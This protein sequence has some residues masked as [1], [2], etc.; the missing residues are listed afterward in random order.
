MG[1]GRQLVAHGPGS[2]IAALGTASRLRR[3]RMTAVQGPRDLDSAAPV[4]TPGG[5]SSGHLLLLRPQLW[6][7][8][9]RLSGSLVSEAHSP[10]EAE[11]FRI[12]S[13]FPRSLAQTLWRDLGLCQRKANL[14]HPPA[15]LNS[16]SLYSKS[17]PRASPK[18]TK[19]THCSNTILLT[20]SPPAVGKWH[21]DHSNVTPPASYHTAP[22]RLSYFHCVI[23]ILKR[24]ELSPEG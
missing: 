9:C 7:S 15:N 20:M 17:T 3:M 23:Y 2:V 5:S 18:F 19:R 1:V 16:S 4:I 6:T 8:F 21:A 11:S 14:K 24:E 13:Y 22:H 12:R 10:A